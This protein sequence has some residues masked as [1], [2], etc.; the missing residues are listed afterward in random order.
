MNLRSRCLEVTFRHGRPIAA[1]YYLPRR[2]GQQSYRTLSVEPGLVVDLSRSGQ[3]LGIEIT[4]P[5]K[6]SVAAVN[7]V[8]PRLGASRVSRA[9][10]APLL[11]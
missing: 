3:P 11:P 8:L 7:R 10:L 4:A 9:E 5:G 2:A 6:V 1:Y